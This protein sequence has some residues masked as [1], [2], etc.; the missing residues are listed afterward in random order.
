M[1]AFPSPYPTMCPEEEESAKSQDLLCRFK[2]MWLKDSGL[3]SDTIY[4]LLMQR[5]G[6]GPTFVGRACS[7]APNHCLW[8]GPPSAETSS[9]IRMSPPGTISSHGPE[10]PLRE[11]RKDQW[12]VM[13]LGQR[14]E[15]S[16]ELVQGAEK[17]WHQQW[18]KPGT[19]RSGFWMPLKVDMIS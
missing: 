5:Q 11:G 12:D 19:D 10:C 2:A 4:L 17:G 8:P 18:G 3:N 16:W 6:P 7:C 15:R 9:K 14:E 1:M 13:T